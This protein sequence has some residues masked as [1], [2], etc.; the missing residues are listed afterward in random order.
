MNENELKITEH[1][2]SRE[3]IGFPK[4]FGSGM[5]GNNQPY[6]VLELLGLSVKDILKQ[7]KRHFTVPCVVTIG[8]QML[9]LLEKF[10]EQ[11]F[12][13]CDL[14]PGNIMIGDYTKD[15]KAM[16]QLYLIDFGLSQR[17]LDDKGKHIPMSTKVPFK[18]NLIYSSKHAFQNLTLSR[19]D[20]IISLA[21]FLIFRI[22]SNQSWIDY[23]RPISEQYKEI[24]IFKIQTSAKKFCD[25][26]TKV[27]S[28]LL[29]YSYSLKFDEKP[30]YDKIRFMIK[31]IMLDNGNVPTNK[32]DWSLGHGE[33]I[34]SI[35]P[36]DDHS[37]MSSCNLGSHEGIGPEN[38]LAF[39]REK[40]LRKFQS[41]YGTFKLNP[42]N[43]P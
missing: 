8:L 7:N 38:L 22:N 25:N 27:L 18:G 28:P 24:G 32:F 19:R 40:N 11:G 43:K 9:D 3:I 6:I 4:V 42:V 16:N 26:E 13:H 1:M 31:K 10:H 41:K 12:V 20:D 15:P 36:K 39:D 37:S 34:Q 29:Q 30:D 17:Y 5:L 35:E 23:Q 21:Y 14:K 33:K 2:S